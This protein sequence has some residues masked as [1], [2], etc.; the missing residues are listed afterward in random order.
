MKARGQL[1]AL[2]QSVPVARRCEAA[3]RSWTA[4]T[5]MGFSR[6]K[7][8]DLHAIS[9]RFPTPIMGSGASGSVT[10]RADFLI[11]R[12]FSYTSY[13]SLWAKPMTQSREIRN[14][15]CALAFG[16]SYCGVAWPL[17]PRSRLRVGLRPKLLRRR[18]APRAALLARMGEAFRQ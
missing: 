15:T 10:A 6:S 17:G 16:Q 4:L 9:Q 18:V 3:F 7:R 13:R 8:P 1:S 11:I 12:L 5:G 2:G 14:T